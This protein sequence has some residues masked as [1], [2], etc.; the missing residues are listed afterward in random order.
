M[1]LG[2]EMDVSQVPHSNPFAAIPPARWRWWRSPSCHGSHK[3]RLTVI[4][5][6]KK[7]EKKKRNTPRTQDTSSLE[8]TVPYTP[9]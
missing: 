5:I 6:S 2:I 8:S 3:S 1:C 4:L 7:K 9:S